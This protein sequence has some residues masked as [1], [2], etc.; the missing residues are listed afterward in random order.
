MKK[1]TANNTTAIIWKRSIWENGFRC[2]R[3]QTKLF[4]EPA[5]EPMNLSTTDNKSKSGELYCSKCGN[6]VGRYENT[7]MRAKRADDWSDQLRKEAL[8]DDE[9]QAEKLAADNTCL[10]NQ[11]GQVNAMLQEEQ[12][13]CRE[14]QKRVAELLTRIEML[15]AAHQAQ[16]RKLDRR[17]RELTDQLE[18]AND[19]GVKIRERLERACGN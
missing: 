16:L 2:T 5:N 10:R 6:L 4:D 12:T 8:A 9:L 14:S 18:E 13:R 17:I 3:C 1:K 15:E 11:L 19:C 7:Y